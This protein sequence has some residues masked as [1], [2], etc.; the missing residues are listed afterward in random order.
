MEAFKSNIDALEQKIELLVQKWA[1]A[2]DEN[3]ELKEKNKNLEEKL[4]FKSSDQ[5]DLVNTD[6]D[7]D[8]K[9]NNI[10]QAIDDYINKI[11]DCL[12]LIN[13]ELNGK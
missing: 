9:L 4:M 5:R 12:K 13:I 8:S 11:D 3:L 10:E 2:R 7:S 6:T 1:K